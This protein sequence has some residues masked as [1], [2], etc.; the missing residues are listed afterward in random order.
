MGFKLGRIE[1]LASRLGEGAYC[2][3][4]RVEGSRK[5]R[6]WREK[7]GLS[8]HQLALLLEVNAATVYRWEQSRAMPGLK[9]AISLAR[10]SKGEVPVES[11]IREE[12]TAA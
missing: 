10:M 8:Q 1:G 7:K 4:M 11:W 9:Q 12:R 5:T 3:V 2:V 6:R